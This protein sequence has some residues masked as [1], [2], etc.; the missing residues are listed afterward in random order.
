MRFRLCPPRDRI[1]DK[2]E[3]DLT[4]HPFPILRL[5]GVHKHGDLLRPRRYLR[6]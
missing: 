2:G 4:D 6:G 3:N 1:A 5:G